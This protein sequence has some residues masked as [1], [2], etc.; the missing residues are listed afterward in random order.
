M[1]INLF[2]DKL[3]VRDCFSIPV[4]SRRIF[5]FVNEVN[6]KRK[7]IFMVDELLKQCKLYNKNSP[8]F[9]YNYF[10]IDIRNDIKNVIDFLLRQ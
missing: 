8:K 4:K 6:A 2:I 3:N 10:K 5:I 7:E 1:I 9:I